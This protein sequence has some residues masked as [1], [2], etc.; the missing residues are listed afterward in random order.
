MH[1]REEN[2][3][4]VQQKISQEQPSRGKQIIAALA[5]IGFIIAIPTIVDRFGK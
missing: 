2:E 1:Q 3:Y 4:P 5:F